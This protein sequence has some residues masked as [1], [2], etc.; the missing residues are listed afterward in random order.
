[1]SRN[2]ATTNH[3]ISSQ[4]WR[5]QRYEQA[6]DWMKQEPADRNQTL[7]R[8]KNKYVWCLHHKLWQKHASKDCRLNPAY[9][10]STT[11]PTEEIN[12]RSNDKEKVEKEKQKSEVRYQPKSLMATTNLQEE[13]DADF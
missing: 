11:S 2:Q 1:M 10:S 13:F 5:K 7:V 3:S 4:E 6:P 12:R 9:V 8:G